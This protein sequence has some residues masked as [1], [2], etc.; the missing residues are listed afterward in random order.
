MKY[1]VTH[2]TEFVYEARVGLS[3]NL[4]RLMPRGLPRQQVLSAVLRITPHPQ[5]HESAL[6]YF[7]NRTDY[8]SIQQPHDE[9]RVT[10]ISEVEVSAPET[11][12]FDQAQNLSW[13]EARD[14][15]RADRSAP[16][17]DALQFTLDSPMVVVED[18]LADYARASFSPGRFLDEA[19]DD[20]MRRIFKDFKYDPEFSSIATPLREVMAH[21]GGVCQDFAHLAIGCL[22][23]QGLAARYV[24]GY[25]ETDPP[26]GKERLVG[27]DA[28]HAW[29]SVYHPVRGW[30]DFDPTNNQQPGERY[31]TLAWGRD[32][33][34]VTPLKG[35]AYGGGEHQLK[36]AVD[37][38]RIS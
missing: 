33:A 1:R 34:D 13:E 5:D 20:L 14:H 32:F 28:S 29:F 22:R 9:L 7:G 30:L 10:A 8:F 31:V 19:V 21:R 27:A 25:L 16:G 23:A 12:L 18:F 15:L 36:V 26:P 24:S 2:T 11:G 38:E 37:V 17:I 4:A 35:V 3:Y 6:D